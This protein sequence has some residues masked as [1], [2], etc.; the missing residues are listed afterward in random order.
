MWNM[1]WSEGR[2]LDFCPPLGESTLFTSQFGQQSNKTISK[3]GN[4]SRALKQTP[5]SRLSFPYSF[6]FSADGP[7]REMAKFIFSTVVPVWWRRGP[8]HAAPDV[9]GEG[10]LRDVSRTLLLLKH[11]ILFFLLERTLVASCLRGQGEVTSD[12]S[13]RGTSIL[14]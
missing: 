9:L 6:W 10:P 14:L 1:T 3:Y 13:L 8:C 7:S 5:P 2:I 12:Y 4:P 11:S